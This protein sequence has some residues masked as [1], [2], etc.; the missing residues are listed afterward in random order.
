MR[1]T[2]VIT[3]A[4]LVVMT[5]LP[6]AAQSADFSGKWLLVPDPAAAPAQGGGPGRRPSPEIDITKDAKTLTLVR[7]T[8][9][10]E[11]KSVYNL[12]GSESKNTMTFGGNSMDQLSK[13]TWSGNTMVVTTTGEVNGNKFESTMALSLDAAGNL[14]LENTFPTPDG[15]K[16]TSKV[17]YKKS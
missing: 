3:S 9:N 1:L 2:S 8:P 16:N 6:A 11:R 4:A 15:G 7:V 13:V 14:V 12:D 10:G 5:A 17:M